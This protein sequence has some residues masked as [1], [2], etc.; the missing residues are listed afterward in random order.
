[1]LDND[2]DKHA[3][4]YA[5]PASEVDKEARSSAEWCDFTRRCAK[6]LHYR[7]LVAG[8]VTWGVYRFVIGLVGAIHEDVLSKVASLILWIVFG[9]VGM[10]VVSRI[11][12]VIDFKTSTVA[13]FVSEFSK[14]KWI[15]DR[16]L[17]V[18]VI[19]AFLL[20]MV[21]ICVE[22]VDALIAGEMIW[23]SLDFRNTLM[24]MLITSL[25]VYPIFRAVCRS[26]YEL[27]KQMRSRL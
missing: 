23:P 27:L 19:A 24:S 8:F 3:N 25:V 14:G 12:A 6:K 15:L 9:S 22:Y 16:P 20:C 21:D 13:K 11:I 4:P 10:F 1:M 17:V 26:H 7:W 2:R 5:A 18:A